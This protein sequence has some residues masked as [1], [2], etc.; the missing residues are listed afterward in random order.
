M[1]FTINENSGLSETEVVINC[2]KA[3]ER[4]LKMVA[5]FSGE[6]QK[7]AGIADGQTFLLN[8]NEI[9]Y[10][11]T[12][13]RKTFIYSA[14]KVFESDLRLYELEERLS[15]MD[16]FRAG[17]SCIINF[18]KIKALRPDFGGRLSVTLENGE[19]QTVSRQYVPSVKRKL[20]IL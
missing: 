8:P 3:D 20:G 10:I 16:F 4:I 15:A 11:E 7:I 13:D 6:N 5:M 9:F 17:K 18:T 19:R 2:Q 12:V 14:K 1:R